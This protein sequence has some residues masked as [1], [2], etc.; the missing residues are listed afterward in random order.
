M[1]AR[2]IRAAL[3]TF[4][5]SGLFAATAHA[6]TRGDASSSSDVRVEYR[7]FGQGAYVLVIPARSIEAP[8][9]LTGR[10]QA[11]GYWDR[12]NVRVIETGQGR[13]VVPATR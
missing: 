1:T 7:Y 8:Y 5:L 9:A 2:S 6:E 4:A 13:I 11:D 3:A 10:R 12:Q